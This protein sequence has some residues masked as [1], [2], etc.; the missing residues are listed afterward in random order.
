MKA[1]SI[2]EEVLTHFMTALEQLV[3]CNYTAEVHRSLALFITY[4]YHSP[5]TSLVRSPRPISAIARTPASSGFA[6][7]ATFDSNST[8]SA[9]PTRFLTKKQLGAKILGIY[10][11]LL[12]EKGNLA[13]IRKFARTVTNKVRP[14]F[15][16]NQ[17]F[18]LSMDQWLLYLLASD[19]PETVVYG[20][21]IL[22]RLLITHGSAYTAKFSGK[23]GGFTIM[24]HRL[25]RW[26]YVPSLWPICF[27]ILF[28]FDVANVDLERNFDFSNLLETFGKARV[29]YPECL[30]VLTSMLQHGL[31]DVMRH[32]EDPNS[33]Q[34]PH[35]LQA[36]G[37]D[38]LETR[39][40]A[41][42]METR[43]IDSRGRF[44]FSIVLKR[45][46]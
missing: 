18:L 40:R 19:D 20:S 41:K 30:Q 16:E 15:G 14:P 4:A 29:L 3:K 1:E 42:S 17:L 7:R 22:A 9:P 11:D 35:N 28:G 34:K 31:K 25:K 24:A 6:R 33:P 27:S 43:G 8:S 2:T 5:T 46:G 44:R 23:T 39:P 32:Q 10:S 13:N 38:G 21:K 26:W 36:S 45:A 12:C 37:F